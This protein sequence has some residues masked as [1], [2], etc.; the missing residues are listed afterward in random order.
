MGGSLTLGRSEVASILRT[1][2]KAGFL[3]RRDNRTEP[4][5][6]TP[7]TDKKTSRPEGGGRTVVSDFGDVPK[8]SVDQNIL[9]PFRAPPGPALFLGLKPQAESYS[10]FG[11]SLPLNQKAGQKLR[12]IPVHI[13]EECE[14]MLTI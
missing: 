5:V 1:D 2:V 7:G 13:F 11:T 6:L 10:P 4:G 8:Q 9:R 12:W 3:S 14:P